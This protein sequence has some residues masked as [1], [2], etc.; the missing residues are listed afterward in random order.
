MKKQEK[1]HAA[2]YARIPS[3]PTEFDEW[4]PEQVW[5]EDE[6][7]DPKQATQQTAAIGE[8]TKVM[9]TALE[10]AEEIR[11][12]LEGRNH[13]DSTQDLREDRER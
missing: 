1:R 8:R 7:G 11:R 10:K 3:Q 5:D 4:E 9:E 12:Q 2:A 6:E 13:S